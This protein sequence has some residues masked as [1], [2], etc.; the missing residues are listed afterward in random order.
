[1]TSDLFYTIIEEL[2]RVPAL[3]VRFLMTL[4]YVEHCGARKLARYE[5][6]QPIGS[7]LLTHVL[8]EYR[9]AEFLRRQ[10][11]KLGAEIPVHL[12]PDYLI[13]GFAVYNYLDRIEAGVIRLIKKTEGLTPIEQAHAVYL[14]V[15][16]ALET[17][18]TKVYPIY[19]ALLVKH[20]LGIRVASIV[21]EEEQHLRAMAEQIY[22]HPILKPLADAALILE[23]RSFTPWMLSVGEESKKQ[24]NI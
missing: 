1:M 5:M 2:I 4:S 18:A 21:A 14:L 7:S 22:R 11:H 15:T 23:Q 17:R 16:F 24:Y 19:D 8:E 9:H 10:A 12:T 3:H 20:A 13:G 6:R